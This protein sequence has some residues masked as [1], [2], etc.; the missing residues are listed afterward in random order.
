M[1][2]SGTAGGKYLQYCSTTG[3]APACAGTTSRNGF[4]AHPNCALDNGNRLGSVQERNIFHPF[5]SLVTPGDA[6]RPGAPAC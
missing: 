6:S 1:Q 2:R 3:G 5:T 4:P